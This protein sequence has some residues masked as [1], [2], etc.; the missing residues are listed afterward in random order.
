MRLQHDALKILLSVLLV[1][2]P[3]TVGCAQ[4]AEEGPPMTANV[5]PKATKEVTVDFEGGETG[6]TPPDFTAALTADGGPPAWVVAEDPSAPAG[7]K[8]LAQTSDDK[9]NKRYPHCV[10][11]KL[12]ARDVDLSVQFRPVSG[13][14][15]QA[16]GL[17]WRYKDKDNYYVV[18]AN[19]LEGNVV[20][21]KTE[22]GVRTDLKLKGK[23]G[24]YGMKVEVPKEKW[25][26]LRV[27]AVGDTFEVFVNGKKLYEVQDQTFSEPGKVGVWTK[28]DSVTYFDNLRV[29][30]LD[31]DRK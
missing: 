16:A 18:R 8:V 15:D 5:L 19:A 31:Q 20:L 10:Y 3:T 28:A 1:T 25:S 14:V 23:S 11:D 6:R 2:G 27:T 30:S 12:A 21:Y 7:G 26:T 24:G 13:T 9:T 17:V 29:S 4:S 22:N